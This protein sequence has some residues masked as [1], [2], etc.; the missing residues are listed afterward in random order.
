M[1]DATKNELNDFTKNN[2][3]CN[4]E[5]TYLF[6]NIDSECFAL[7]GCSSAS[8]A[9]ELCQGGCLVITDENYQDEIQEQTNSEHPELSGFF[10]K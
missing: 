4:P 5:L 7:F 9:F 6:Q 10:L 3:D 1:A 8:E 2:S